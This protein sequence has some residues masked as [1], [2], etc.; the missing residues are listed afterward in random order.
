MDRGPGIGSGSSPL[1]RG[2]PRRLLD[3]LVDGGL[4]PAHAG[5]TRHHQRPHPHRRAHPRSRGEN[6]ILALILKCGC[7]SSPLTRGKHAHRLDDQRVR[8]LIPAHAGKTRR[9]GRLSSMTGAHPRS[10]GENFA[11]VREIR[12]AGGSSPLTRGK[13]RGDGP[14]CRAHGLIPAHAGKTCTHRYARSR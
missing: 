11:R 7:G 9:R 1:T 10:R 12:Q 2:K 8:G 14:R 3:V 5:K 4:I 13:R 6:P